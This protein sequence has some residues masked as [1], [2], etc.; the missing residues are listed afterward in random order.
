MKETHYAYLL[1]RDTDGFVAPRFVLQTEKMFD[2]LKEISSNHHEGLFWVFKQFD[3]MPQEPL[4]II[5]CAPARIYYHYSG[6]VEDLKQ[7]M[8]RL[9]S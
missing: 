2:L 4:C 6:E 9:A 8:I 1:Q 5:D 3:A 7:T